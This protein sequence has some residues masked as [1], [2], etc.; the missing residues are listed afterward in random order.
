MNS[1]PAIIVIK[2]FQVS[3][4]IITPI[5]IAKLAMPF[6]LHVFSHCLKALER[7]TPLI[8]IQACIIPLNLEFKEKIKVLHIER[9]HH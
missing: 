4:L 5:T 3:I 8:A 7:L 6:C 1:K 2:L 9:K